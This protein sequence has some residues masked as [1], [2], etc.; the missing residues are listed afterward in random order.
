M[1]TQQPSAPAKATFE[2]R[3]VIMKYYA[4]YNAGDVDAVLSLMADDC[5]YHDMIYLEPFVGKQAIRKYFEKVT[6]VVP[7]D[8][9]FNLEEMSGGD[10]HFVGVKW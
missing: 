2:A 8:L 1:Q 7:R 5:Q 10:P 3:E 6:S 4:A 9:K